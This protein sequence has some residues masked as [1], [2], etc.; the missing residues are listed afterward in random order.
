ME[1]KEVVRVNAD[2][3][4][5][6][7]DNFIIWRNVYLKPK[8]NYNKKETEEAYSFWFDNVKGKEFWK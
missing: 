3:K 2:I 1:F 6:C 5:Q 4:E 8:K 7:K